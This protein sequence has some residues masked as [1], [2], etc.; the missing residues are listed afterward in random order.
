MKRRRD[1]TPRR[2]KLN[3]EGRLRKAKEWI[4]TYTQDRIIKAY[5]RWFGV[6]WICALDELKLA[7]V[8]ISYEEEQKILSACDARILQKRREKQL[9]KAKSNVTSV[10]NNDENEFGFDIVIGYTSGGF[11]Y[12]IN[13]EPETEQ[14]HWAL[15][16]QQLEEDE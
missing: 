1:N 11:P 6:D 7:G 13:L 5:A 10:M 3:R 9:R 15:D 2:K 4:A 8:R 16:D 12:G 14:F